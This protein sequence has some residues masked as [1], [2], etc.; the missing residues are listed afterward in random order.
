MKKIFTI[1][2]IATA[3]INISQAQ[4]I[5]INQTGALPN[6]S[7]MLDVVSTTKGMLIPRMTSAQKLAINGP[8]TGL[9]IFQNR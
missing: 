9:L 7:A 6:N 3:V 2:L 4:N 8:A 1:L 5:G